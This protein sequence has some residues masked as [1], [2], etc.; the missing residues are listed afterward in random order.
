MALATARKAEIVEKFKTHEGDTGSP[1]VQVALL[2]ERINGLTEHFKS[3]KKD[4]H[5]RRGLL[6]LVSKRKR[7]LS[8]LKG[9]N[10]ERYRTLIKELGLRK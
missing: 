6:L 1:E 10:V 3:H 5:S 7:L 9:R 4:H 8:Y 2:T